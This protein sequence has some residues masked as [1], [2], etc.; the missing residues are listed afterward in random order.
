MTELPDDALLWH[1]L[2][3][4]RETC[5]GQKCRNF[6]TCFVTKVRRQALESDII[7]V[8]HHLFFADLALRQGDFASIL[9]DY[10]VL[11]FDEAHEIED[12]A[13]QY[14]GVMI[15][16]YR[17]EELVRDADRALTETGAASAFL[18]EQL[19]KLAERSKEFF[20]R[21]QSKEGRFVLQP[22]GSGLG[23][24]RG[25]HGVD[26]IS[27]SYR[28]L[29]TQLNVLRIFS[30]QCPRSE[31]KHRCP[32]AQKPGDGERIGNNPRI[33]VQRACV[34]GARYAAAVLF[35]GRPP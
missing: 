20:A 28:A 5:S 18:T 34:S 23:V 2:D 8:N 31:R 7:I 26:S 24:R 17:I 35:S 22:L 3:A 27:D 29:R 33:R 14:F 19:A 4:R 9:P 30:Q 21:F 13:T 6:D 16:N 10:S 15:S 25:L 11:V 32:G 12:V 1:R